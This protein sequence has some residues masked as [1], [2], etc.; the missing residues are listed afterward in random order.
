MNLNENSKS[1]HFQQRIAPSLEKMNLNKY[2]YFKESS[3]KSAESTF[4]RNIFL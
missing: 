2:L 3:T 1:E 4:L